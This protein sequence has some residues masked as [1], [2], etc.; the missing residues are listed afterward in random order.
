MRRRTRDRSQ[1]QASLLRPLQGKANPE[2]RRLPGHTRPPWLLF[3]LGGIGL[4]LVLI[5]IGWL[6][7]NSSS[8]LTYKAD[9][10]ARAGDWNAALSYWRA[11]NATAAARSSS[12]LGEARACLALGRAAQAEHS[13]RQAVSSNPSDTE[14]WLLLLEIL[15]IE[16]RTLEAQH[17]GW[18][19][20]NHVRSDAQRDLL[21]ALTLGLLADLPDEQVRITL[22]RWIDA[23]Q[24]DVDAQ[25]ALWQRI[26]LQPRAVDPNRL[27]VL[28]ELEALL[29]K[30]PDHI[31]TR[32]ALVTTLA[33]LGEPD[34]GRILLDDWPE[35]MRDARYWRL[36]GRWDLEY[37]HRPQE[38]VTALQTAIAD[39]PQDWR[40][41][42]RLA[43]ALHVL[44]RA[45]ESQR[46]AETVSRIREVLDPLI[47][48]PRLHAAFNHLDDSIALRDLAA[49]CNR[50][51]LSRLADAW[52]AEARRQ[53]KP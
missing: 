46:A 33:D 43:R 51:G 30:Y 49:L 14:S 50:A 6:A 52:L 36:R 10:A 37:D 15:L 29:T 20:Y 34:R 32:E 53:A 40:S 7:G 2:R 48:E 28:A 17:L 26:A 12:F 42:Y 21:R 3:T 44:G 23:D 8:S 19:A 22:H 11:I 5:L 39:L 45:S 4:L 41:W 27:A 1:T 24:A 25:I 13:L 18:E 35:S 9:A 38:A 16:D 47:L 31:N